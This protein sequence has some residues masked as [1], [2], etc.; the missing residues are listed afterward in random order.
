MSIKRNAYC[1]LTSK[2]A[3][4]DWEETAQ[5]AASWHVPYEHSSL[6]RNTIKEGDTLQGDL[7][8]SMSIQKNP[9]T[10][11]GGKPSAQPDRALQTQDK[12]HLLVWDFAPSHLLGKMPEVQVCKA[13]AKSCG[14]LRLSCNN[15]PLCTP[16]A[17]LRPTFIPRRLPPPT[18]PRLSSMVTLRN[19]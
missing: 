9:E 10:H 1:W 17:S 14:R 4:P 2:L 7:H 12:V 3:A 13:K 6:S 19:G 16:A 15:F 5:F 18:G 11:P 8:F